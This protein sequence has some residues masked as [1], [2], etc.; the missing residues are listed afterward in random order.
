MGTEFPLRRDPRSFMTRNVLR[1]SEGGSGSGRWV[2]VFYESVSAVKTSSYYVA[3]A[4]N[5]SASVLDAR[6]G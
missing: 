5:R 3:G 2:L 1:I 6:P 4:M